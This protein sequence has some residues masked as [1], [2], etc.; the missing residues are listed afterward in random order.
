M[1]A[2]I[3][4]ATLLITATTIDDAVWLIPYCTANHLP[5][6][7]KII[8]ASTFIL[9]LQLLA[10]GCIIISKIFQHVILKGGSSSSVDSSFLFQLIGALM[11][12]SIAIFLYVKKMRKKRRQTLKK[13]LEESKK[14]AKGLLKTSL[15]LEDQP[16]I[17]ESAIADEVNR[18]TSP[19]KGL[20]ASSISSSSNSSESNV[21]EGSDIPIEPSIRMVMTL[22]SLGALDEIS[23]F[24]AL[25]VGNVFSPM[26]LLVGTFLASGLVL[27]LVLYFLARVKPLVNFLDNIPLYVIVAM[28]A[29]I[30]TVGL[31]F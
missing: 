5:T 31:F 27:I 10:M 26:Q 19:Q 11:C 29:L 2:G 16:L 20:E 15:D 6:N 7:T 14:L 23:Y 28:F 9:T 17:P 8:H 13:A 24:P 12:W 1:T 21:I 4:G 3:L 18:T 30:L 22:T 25:L